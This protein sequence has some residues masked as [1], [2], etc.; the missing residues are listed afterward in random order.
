MEFDETILNKVKKR[1]YIEKIIDSKSYDDM[2]NEME[3]FS[4]RVI[5]LTPNALQFNKQWKETFDI[6]VFIQL[7]RHTNITD[8][9]INHMMEVVFD[10]LLKCCA[11][12]QDEAIMHAKQTLTNTNGISQKV[13]QMFE[14]AYEIIEDIERML[15]K[16]ADDMEKN[17]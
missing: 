3:I 16:L 14:I 4:E 8:I 10:H 2:K 1:L 11:P 15:N 5:S 6:D 17:I 9:E 12:S 7:M 13:S